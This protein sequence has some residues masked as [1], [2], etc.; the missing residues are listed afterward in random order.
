MDG[1]A[2]RK[3]APTHMWLEHREDRGQGGVMRRKPG[4]NLADKDTGIY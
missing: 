2:T 4:T 1:R 3:A